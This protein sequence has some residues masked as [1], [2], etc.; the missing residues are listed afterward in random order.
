[1]SVNEKLAKDE[2]GKDVDPSLYISMIGSLLYLTGSKPDIFF[3]VR[4]CA[5][6]QASPKESHLTVIKGIIWYVSGTAEFRI[7]YSGDSNIHLAGYND[8]D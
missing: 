7:W 4:V 8:V 5:R 2:H 1:M 3:S 6:Y